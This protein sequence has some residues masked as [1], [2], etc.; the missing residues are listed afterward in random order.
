MASLLIVYGTTEGHTRKL[1]GRVATVA[2]EHHHSATVVDSAANTRLSDARRYDAVVVA[3]SLHGGRH[4]PSLVRW[5]R[6]NR[7]ALDSL[8]TAFFSVSL[9]AAGKKERERRGAREC[10]DRFVAETGWIPG[11]V[12]LVAGKLAYSK[13]PFLVRQAM[14][15]IAWRA[16]GDTDTSRDYEYTDWAALRA[17]VEEFLLRAVPAPAESPAAP[18]PEPVGAA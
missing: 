6:A 8:P 13:Y 12:R 10:A 15:F 17:D 11:M 18:E 4:Q 2:F 16:G 14:R 7:T 5:V 3:G 9:S 1:A